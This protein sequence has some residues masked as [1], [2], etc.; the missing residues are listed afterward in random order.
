MRRDLDLPHIAFLVT[1]VQNLFPGEQQMFQ[2]FII[3]DASMLV[4]TLS[5][6]ENESQQKLSR[7]HASQVCGNM[8]NSFEGNYSFK[9]TQV[10]AGRESFL[11]GRR[12]TIV[13]WVQ[14]DKQAQESV[15][16]TSFHTDCFSLLIPCVYHDFRG[17]C[18]GHISTSRL[19]SQM[20]ILTCPS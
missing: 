20:G 10:N 2:T 16:K 12:Q 15:I 4:M 6:C 9:S 1:F 17:R 5:S 7:Y 3:N 13:Q 18:F 14:R 19:R 8:P 11:S